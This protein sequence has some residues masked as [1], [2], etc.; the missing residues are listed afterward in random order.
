MRPHSTLSSV[1]LPGDRVHRSGWRAATRG[2][3]LVELIVVLVLLLFLAMMAVPS[4][5]VWIRNTQIRNTATSIQAGLQRARAEAMRRNEVVRFSL[6]TLGNPGLMD[7]SCAV[8]ENGLSWVVSLDDP[9]GKCGE[10]VSD[11][12]APRMIDSH[13]TGGTSKAAKVLGTAA[14]GEDAAQVL[15][16]GFGRVTGAGSISVVDID[17]ETPGDDY[18]ALRIMVGLG[19]TVRM[20][21]PKVSTVSDPR[22]C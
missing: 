19:G 2:L 17:N 22:A 3:T 1:S 6:V 11:A 9:A 21:E 14:N 4:V 13:A 15:F 5:Q 12:T 10:A 20:C 16:D 8:A 18:R 7:N